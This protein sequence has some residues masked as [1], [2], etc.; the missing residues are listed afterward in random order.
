MLRLIGC[1]RGYRTA[2]PGDRK[3]DELIRDN[4]K[5]INRPRYIYSFMKTGWIENITQLTD[6]KWLGTLQGDVNGLTA[7]RATQEEDILL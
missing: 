4:T 7:A 1:C 3:V 5:Q 6:S 2:V